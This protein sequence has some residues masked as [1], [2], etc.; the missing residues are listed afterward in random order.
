MNHH[1]TTIIFIV[2]FISKVN[3]YSFVWLFSQFLEMGKV[4]VTII[5]DQD[6]TIKVALR[7]VSSSTD[8]VNDTLQTE[9]L[10]RLVGFT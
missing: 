9:W 6:P 10:I 7:I 5:T 2:G 1:K 3:T 8:F 4:I